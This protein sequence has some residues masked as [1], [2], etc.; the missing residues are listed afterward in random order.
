[1]KQCEIFFALLRKSTNVLK[2]EISDDS[3]RKLILNLKYRYS[4]LQPILRNLLRMMATDISRFE[5]INEELLDDVL[6]NKYRDNPKVF[7]EYPQVKDTENNKMFTIYSSHID[8]DGV[9]VF[10][11]SEEFHAFIVVYYSLVLAKE[12]EA[13]FIRERDIEMKRVD[14]LSDYH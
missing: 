8:L 4:M 13:E 5:I 10:N 14:T 3:Q 12:R 11:E 7:V 1:M 2:D 9:T 6:Q